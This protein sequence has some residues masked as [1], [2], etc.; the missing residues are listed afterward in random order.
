MC[1]EATVKLAS[2]SGGGVLDLDVGEVELLAVLGQLV[3]LLQQGGKGGRGRLHLGDGRLLG[4][5]VAVGVLKR[6]LEGL[7]GEEKEMK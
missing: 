5:G 6:G 1:G 2:L 3:P 4:E 7:C